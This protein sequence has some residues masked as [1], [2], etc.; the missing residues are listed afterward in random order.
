M[1]KRT[2]RKYL[3]KPSRSRNGGEARWGNMYREALRR[4]EASGDP[5]LQDLRHFSGD[6]EQAL[7]R[8]SII[9]KV[10]LEREFPG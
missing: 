10:D 6:P 3:R 5:R 4:A 8:L 9:S 1:A 2:M 7:R